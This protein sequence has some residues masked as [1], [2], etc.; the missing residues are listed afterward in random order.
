MKKLLI[1]L[2]I[3]FGGCKNTPCSDSYLIPVF[4]GFT[5]SDIDTVVYR[6][7]IPNDNFNHLVDTV[8]IITGGG[9]KLHDSDSLFVSTGGTGMVGSNTVKYG[10][11]D[12]TSGHDWS[13]YLPAIDTTI[14]ISEIVD[15]VWESKQ[16][17]GNVCWNPIK[18]CV[19]NGKFTKIEYM[20]Y[21]YAPYYG[22]MLYI[23]K[24]K[25]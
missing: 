10:Y 4:I 20:D 12:L 14:Y 19:V 2:F 24:R 18:S 15:S 6:A 3:V 9:W 23:N 17:L 1:L 25:D 13:I 11:Q 8:L 22:Y 21:G 5:S 16:Y 7:Y